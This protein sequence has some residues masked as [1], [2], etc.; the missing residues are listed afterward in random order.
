LEPSVI[1]YLRQ[2]PPALE[3]GQEPAPVV[4]VVGRDQGEG[5]G[6]V[7]ERVGGQQ[8]GLLAQ[9]DFV[10]AQGAG[11]VLDGPLA[12]V[13]P[14]ALADLPVQ[15]VIDKAVGQLQ[16]EVAGQS[17]AQPLDTHAVVEHAVEDGFTD[18]VG[19]LG[20]GQD[21]LDLGAEGLAAA[22]AGAILCGGQ[23]DEQDL[24]VGE[25]ADG[26]RVGLLAVSGD[27]A[28][29]AGVGGGG[30]AAAFDAD[31][32][33]KVSHACVTPGG[34]V[35]LPP[36]VRRLLVSASSPP[37]LLSCRVQ[38]G[39]S[40]IARTSGHASLPGSLCVLAAYK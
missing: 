22:T 11:E 4:L 25:A 20:A 36:G 7:V 10:D 27:A 9:V 39:V 28:A 8:Q 14:V 17:A 6:E 37:G 38:R 5:H 13:G 1:N 2:E 29:G 21:A 15:A 23:L 33:L 24:A 12:V 16:V 19:V 34:W 32:R 40:Q 3:V 30:A 31:G 18:A 35:R 26:A